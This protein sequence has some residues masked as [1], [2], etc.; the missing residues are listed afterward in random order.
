MKSKSYLHVSVVDWS[1]LEN[2]RQTLVVR[3]S[4]Q[5]KADRDGV[6]VR[7]VL[8][9]KERDVVVSTAFPVQRESV[10]SFDVEL[11]TG[12]SC[13]TLSHHRI[14]AWVPGIFGER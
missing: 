11:Q 3:F 12:P 9:C 10:N 5:R 6:V 14:V 4:G 8:Q 13:L 7:F 1:V 2:I